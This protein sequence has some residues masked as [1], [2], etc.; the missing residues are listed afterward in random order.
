MPVQVSHLSPALAGVAST[1]VKLL[2]TFCQWHLSLVLT[3]TILRASFVAVFFFL[4]LIVVLAALHPSGGVMT[5]P[6]P[7]LCHDCAPLGKMSVPAPITC[8]PSHTTFTRSQSSSLYDVMLLSSFSVTDV[9][10]VGVVVVVFLITLVSCFRLRVL[11]VFSLTVGMRSPGSLGANAY[12]SFAGCDPRRCGGGT[13]PVSFTRPHTTVT[14]LG[15]V[16]PE[17][18]HEAQA[19]SPVQGG[20]RR[21]CPGYADGDNVEMSQQPWKRY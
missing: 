10:Y 7:S 21:G 20:W 14:D 3:V 13:C 1:T 17:P 6:H 11:R 12:P 18:G 19:V 2:F 16:A 9:V 5:H 4:H 15:S 8:S